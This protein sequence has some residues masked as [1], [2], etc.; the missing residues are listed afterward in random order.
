[1]YP[2]IF[3]FSI[4]PLLLLLCPCSPHIVIIVPHRSPLLL[5]LCPYIVIVMS[6]RIILWPIGLL[7][8]E[9]RFFHL[10]HPKI[11]HLCNVKEVSPSK[12][13]ISKVFISLIFNFVSWFRNIWYQS[14]GLQGFTAPNRSSWNFCHNLFSTKV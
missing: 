11:V 12:R 4:A 7:Y 1:M 2:L 8:I 6:A 10:Y 14:F 3:I 9:R 13:L 5:L